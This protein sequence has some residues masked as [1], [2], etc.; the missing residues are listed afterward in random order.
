[1]W[2]PSFLFGVE[3]ITVGGRRASKGVHKSAGFIAR[4]GDGTPSLPVSTAYEAEIS[5][6]PA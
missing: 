4:H 6:R 1:M 5:P 2:G 3:G